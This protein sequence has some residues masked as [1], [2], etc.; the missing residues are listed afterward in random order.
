MDD[1]SIFPSWFLKAV[2]VF[3]IVFI[4]V[5]VIFFI[6]YQKAQS[7]LVKTVSPPTL[8]FG[9]NPQ[10]LKK[11]ES[12]ELLIQLDP[13]DNEIHAFDIL[14]RY[15]DTK[16]AFQSGFDLSAHITS[17]YELLRRD[18]NVLTAI[19]PVGKTIHIVGANTKA[20]FSALTVIARVTGM[21]KSDAVAGLYPLFVWD[22]KTRLGD[23]LKITEIEEKPKTFTIAQ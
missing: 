2:L 21:I 4:I 12:F 18:D 9:I 11:G 15:D 8:S 5:V 17:S 1:E 10:K 23:Y 20:A 19:D 16:V 3:F 14:I 7:R 22:A 6:R 13:H